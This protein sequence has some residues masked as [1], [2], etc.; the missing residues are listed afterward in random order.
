MN[1]SP[2]L[3]SLGFVRALL[4]ALA[5]ATFAWAS[6]QNP[7]GNYAA[8]GAPPQRWEVNA[9]HTLIWGGSP[10][11]PVGLR[12][13]GSPAEVERAK[14]AGF[15]DVIVDLPAGGTGWDATLQALEKNQ[16][17]Y[18]ISISSL[19]P[20]A[21]GVAIE[22][23]GYRITGISEPQKVSV[24]LPGATGALVVLVNKRDASVAKA[25]R[26]KV[27]D[28]VLSLDVKPFASL[29]QVVLIY[30]RMRSLEQPDL[31]EALDE[32]RDRLL[33]TLKTHP[34]GAGLRG[35]L[36]PMGRLATWTKTDPQFVPT[37]PYFR[38][39]FAAYLKEKYRGN[40]QTAQ[41]AWSMT[42]SDIDSFEAM[43]R[44]APLWS[45]GSRGIPQLWDTDSDK[46]YN[47]D[48]RHSLIWADIQDAIAITAARRA[49]RLSAAIKSVLDVPIVQEW[50]GWA[51]AYETPNPPLDG[52]GMR[53]VGTSPSE[54]LES[55]SRATSSILRWRKS[56]WLLASDVD[57][58]GG[59]DVAA[60][61]SA[62]LDDLTSMGARGWF[63]RASSDPV[64]KALAAQG[65]RSSDASLAQYSPTALFYPEVAFN[66]ATPQLL[67]GGRWWLPSPADGNRIDLGDHYFAYRYQYLGQSFTALWS[68]FPSSRTKLK[69]VDGKN[70]TFQSVDGS[71][72]DPRL[73]RDGVQLTMGSIPIIIAG[74]SEIP[75]PDYA[76]Q[77]LLAYSDQLFA[78][79][80]A[81]MLDITQERYLF[82]DALSGFDRNPGGAYVAMRQAFESVDLRLGRFDWIEAEKAK[83][84]NFSEVAKNAGCSGGACLA[85]A[86]QLA[87]PPSGY[88]A[89]YSV[90]VKTGAD[91]E[92]WVAARIPAD[93]R[94]NVTV[95]I[96]TQKFSLD[97]NPTNPYGQGFAWYKLGITKLAG[98]LSTLKVE[99][100]GEAVD[101]AFDAFLL[102]PGS[103]QP[104]GVKIPPAIDFVPVKKKG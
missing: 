83:A 40:L 68:D 37:S 16:M 44:L 38:Y 66:P 24:K 41:R 14:A 25:V 56:G 82:K 52:I 67:P 61:L 57:P 43:A 32:H 22:P 76:Y 92:V 86:T 89:E 5:T 31:W 54:L 104:R 21:E 98:T 102:Y 78:A 97:V 80:D 58:G 6:A 62:V 75:I 9:N 28:G 45:G 30:P 19:A 15:Q 65:A 81:A 13:D 42:A 33:A 73:Q 20:M 99:V 29:E 70:A 71:V 59:A 8:P 91:L 69:M 50:A 4:V 55:G 36:N 93:Q 63:V 88:S 77:E 17:R 35:I 3:G 48:Y 72:M 79:A 53:P 87:A 96:G 74:T 10:Y 103:F 2:R 12:I 64:L 7:T 1:E 39:E 27:L 84:N 60:Q 90:P 94:K 101:M 47:C 95:T 26:E 100:S 34:A 85:L 18:L 11:L 49:E 51:P 46:L 23:A